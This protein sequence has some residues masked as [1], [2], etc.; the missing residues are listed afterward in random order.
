MV[1]RREEARLCHLTIR[2]TKPT[3]AACIEF[4]DYPRDVTRSAS[5]RIRVA[6]S[7][8]LADVPT[9]CELFILM[10]DQA[11]AA[12]IELTEGQEAANID[13][14]VGSSADSYSVLG[15][16]T[17]SEGGL[18][19]PGARIALVLNPKDQERSG[20]FYNGLATNSRGEFRV[21]GLGPGRYGAYVSSENEGGAFYSDPAYFE[22]IDKDVSG[23]EVKAI[24]G[25]SLS[26]IVV[27]EGDA[28]KSALTQLAGLRV[29]ASIMQTSRTQLGGGGSSVVAA[30]GSFQV[31]GLRPGR[32]SVGVSTFG[33]SSI[34]PSIVRIEHGGIGLP[35]GFEIQPGQSVSGLRVVISYGTGTIRGTVRFEGGNV[36]ADSRTY[37]SCKREGANEGTGAQMDSRGHFVVNNLAPGS[38]ELNLQV[39]VARN[40]TY[41]SG[42]PQ[43]QLVSVNNDAEAE[44]IFTVDLRPK[45][46]G[47]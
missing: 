7:Y 9:I 5:G 30:D 20:S 40:S 33:S 38:Y 21:D 25:L 46:G 17:D 13:I 26:G 34:R 11:K 29:S 24:R 6:A 42:P 39:S 27:T 10:C 23:V 3:I 2:C 15:R 28:Q 31:D 44:V 8:L 18:P 12:V 22:V 41:R 35:Q 19:V 47:P 1:T 37:I 32:I 16:V 36:P 14:K 43:K 45:E 4:M